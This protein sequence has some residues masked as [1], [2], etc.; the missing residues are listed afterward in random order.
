MGPSATREVGFHSQVGRAGHEF[1][2]RVVA[3]K[4]Q[5]LIDAAGPGEPANRN[6]LE[7]WRGTVQTLTKL[8]G[9]CAPKRL[10]R[11]P[12]RPIAGA[13]A[14]I[15][16]ERGSVAG[17]DS[18]ATIVLREQADDKTRGAVTALRAAR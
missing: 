16:R 10:R 6:R 14:E 5:A 15:A 1:R 13:P 2:G 11:I 3:Q 17:P 9:R 18:I 4:G 7:I 12:N 8:V